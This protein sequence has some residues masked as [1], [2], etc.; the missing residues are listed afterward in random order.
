MFSLESD[1]G[2]SS[3]SIGGVTVRNCHC[4]EVI[5]YRGMASRVGESGSAVN[6]TEWTLRVVD[7]LGALG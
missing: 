3:S 5:C 6:R 7:R 2:S 4:D 1:S